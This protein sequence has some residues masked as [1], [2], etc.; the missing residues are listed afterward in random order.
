MDAV[1]YVHLCP[2]QG[3]LPVLQRRPF[4]AVV[5]IDADVAENWQAAVSEWLV[6]SG[7]L[8]MT[9][10]G[11]NCSSWDDSV[12]FANMKAFDFGEVPDDAFVMTTWHDNEPL[13]QAFWFSR[14]AAMHPTTEISHTYL[15]HIAEN[16]AEGLMTETYRNAE[17]A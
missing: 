14:F 3:A 13:V 5:V 11:K 12:D 8:Y 16:A 4:K 15:V 1:S 9:A 7:C 6:A 10:W 2:G 17:T